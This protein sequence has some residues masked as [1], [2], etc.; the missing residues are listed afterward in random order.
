MSVVERLL[1]TIGVGSAAL[2]A[3]VLTKQSPEIILGGAGLLAV[4]IARELMPQMRITNKPKL[5][6]SQIPKTFARFFP[7]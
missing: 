6:T 2:T 5:Q 1:V 3:M 4:N 7:F